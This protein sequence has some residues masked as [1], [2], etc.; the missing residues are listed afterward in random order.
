MVAEVL[1]RLLAPA[2]ACAGSLALA[3]RW[4]RFG[5]QQHCHWQFWMARCSCLAT[6]Q[7]VGTVRRGVPATAGPTARLRLGAAV[8][9]GAGALRGANDSV[10]VSDGCAEMH[11]LP[12]AELDVC[13]GH[14][15]PAMARAA[16]SLVR[17]IDDEF[18]KS[19]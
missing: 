17:A 15:A 16:F 5:R 3:Q 4:A 14:P 11:P 6:E 18:T 9:G 7:P 12:E 2:D 10:Y 1:G 19:F 13:R 8:Q